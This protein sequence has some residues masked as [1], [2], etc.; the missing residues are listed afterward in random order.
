MKVA[1]IIAEYNP[2][3][4]GHAWQLDAAREQ[5][6]DDL[7]FVAIMSGCLTQRGE[8]AVLDK[9]SR[10]HMALACGI[11]LVVELPFVY[12][13]ASAERFAQGGVGL[14]NA[15]GLNGHLVF[16]SECGDLAQ[17]QRLADL[18]N[19]E[20]PD[21]RLLLRQYL[22][23]GKSFAAARQEA[24]TGLTGDAEL[25]KIL[26]NANNILAVEYLK[27]M[28]QSG[29]RHLIPLTFQ[30]QGQAYLEHAP[31]ITAEG[32]A[33]A[34]SIRRLINSNRCHQETNLTFSLL[35]SLAEMMPPS[36]LA[37][38]SERIQTGPGPLEPEDLAKPIIGRL[39]SLDPSQLDQ[40]PG[41][42][43]GLGRRLASAAARPSKSRD[44]SRGRLET[45]LS[46]AATKRFPRTRIQR[47]LM[48]MLAGLRQEDLSLFDQQGG[49]QYLRILGFDKKG[50]HLLKIMRRQAKL[51]ILMN[52]SD[53]LEHKNDALIR[54]AELDGI[55]TDLWMLAA[56][57]NCGSDFDTPPVMR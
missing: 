18:L 54:M 34:A 43:E 30:R 52:M 19:Q 9:W 46:D 8:P 40:I 20:P 27:A 44:S 50:R 32:F 3:H 10:T 29:Q 31:A 1:F 5:L 26:G 21:F 47:A 49:P 57:K 23:Q 4:L 41:M 14:A 22:D 51:P 16:G 13:T 2:F 6:G 48:A 38:L 36:A 45:L 15:T 33:S 39:R 24:I 7:A 12:A 55:S 37:V 17:L 42:H 25:G 35:S 53:R 56:G 28:G 11:S